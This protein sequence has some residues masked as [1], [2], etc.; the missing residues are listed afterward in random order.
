MEWEARLSLT[1]GR[2][3]LQNEKLQKDTGNEREM[4]TAFLSHALPRQKQN[5]TRELLT[6][7]TYR[8]RL[9]ALNHPMISPTLLLRLLWYRSDQMEHFYN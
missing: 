6:G 4:S 3:E 1:Q 7:F 9:R 5:A 8:I 2:D